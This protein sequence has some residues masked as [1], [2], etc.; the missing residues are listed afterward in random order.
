MAEVQHALDA[1]ELI[2]IR[3]NVRERDL[4]LALIEQLLSALPKAQKVQVIG[5]ALILYLAAKTPVIQ[6]P[7]R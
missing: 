5:H 7:R 4:R 2:K 1:H 3:L 6:L